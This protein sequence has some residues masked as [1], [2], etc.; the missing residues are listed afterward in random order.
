MK[1]LSGDLSYFLKFFLTRDFVRK[2]H[3]LAEDFFAK[4]MLLNLHF[5]YFQKIQIGV[6]LFVIDYSVLIN[7]IVLSL[8]F[9]RE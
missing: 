4:L 8:C 3:C 2:R 9:V 1:P 5:R 7:T 6:I